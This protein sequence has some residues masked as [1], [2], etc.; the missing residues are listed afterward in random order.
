MSKDIKVLAIT[1]LPTIGNAGLKN[2]MSI[3]GTRLIPVPSL[4][5]SG[6]GNMSGHQRFDLPFEE[7]LYETFNMADSRGH[8][9]IVYTG[10]LNSADQADVIVRAIKD[11]DH[12]INSVIVDPVCGDHGK[13]YV[14]GKII[15]RI[16]ELLQ[17][18]HWALPNVTELRILNG[19][20]F[21]AE[22][23]ELQLDFLSRFP[24]INLIT[25][26][27]QRDELVFNDFRSESL[28]STTAHRYLNESIPG[29]GD[30]F[31]AFFIDFHFFKRL[32]I[33]G[34]LQKAGD[35]LTNLIEQSL[36]KA[37]TELIIEPN[38]V[39]NNLEFKVN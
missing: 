8:T 23:S 33:P 25:T 1:S 38:P 27:I 30:A 5:I 14:E 9:L 11:F 16:P 13:A 24:G 36:M 18:A 32:S 19:F 31:A 12:L 35:S 6:L 15:E 29:T 22:L 34:A 17:K 7:L 20:D 26:G 2:M 37:S 4:L 10:Y 39:N 3:L 21:D 28:Y